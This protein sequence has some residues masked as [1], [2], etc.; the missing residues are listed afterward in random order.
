MLLLL[1]GVGRLFDVIAREY[2]KF[3]IFNN[4]K[5]LIYKNNGHRQFVLVFEQYIMCSIHV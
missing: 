1:Q 4:I 2:S 5:K 3:Y